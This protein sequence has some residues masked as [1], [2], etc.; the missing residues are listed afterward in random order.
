MFTSIEA[1]VK[2][3]LTTHPFLVIIVFYF[4]LSVPM[5]KYLI[6]FHSPLSSCSIDVNLKIFD[7]FFRLHFTV[8]QS[9]DLKSST[10]TIEVNNIIFIKVKRNRELFVYVVALDRINSTIFQ[11]LNQWTRICS[12]IFSML[13]N[14]I[15]KKIV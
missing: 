7:D 15:N 9:V 3:R 10:L 6:N 2:R 14:Y 11:T 8:G 4:F 12:I 13:L 1:L 5:A